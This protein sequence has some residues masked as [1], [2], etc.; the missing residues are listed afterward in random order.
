M[1]LKNKLINEI[2]NLI[3]C[4]VKL[5]KKSLDTRGSQTIILYI[6]LILK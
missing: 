2:M 3:I 4:Q 6:R 1:I 5:Y